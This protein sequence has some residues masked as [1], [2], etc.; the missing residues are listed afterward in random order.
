MDDLPITDRLTI[1]SAELRICFARSGG[2]GGQNVNKVE[3]KVEL[4]WTPGESATLS[5]EDRE[6]L[7]KRLAK[8]L[9][10]D[11]DLVVTSQ[12]TRDQVRNREDARAK[13]ATIILRALERPKRRK[14]TRRSRASI[15]RRLREK[16]QQSKLKTDR[17]APDEF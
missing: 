9:T 5:Q 12:R 2:P 17:R 14:R 11:G 3:T 15:E 16:K 10:S 13:M 1:P 7:L 8:K 4:R 6:W